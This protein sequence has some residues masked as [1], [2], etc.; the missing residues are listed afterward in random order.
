MSRSHRKLF[1]VLAAALFLSLFPSA[2]YA[3]IDP[4]A[5]GLMLQ[6]ILGGVF[7]LAVWFRE[8]ILRW[9]RIILRLGRKG[10]P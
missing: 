3:Y 10:K 4:T 1:A 7:G 6:V 5:G 9:A 8:N 2:C